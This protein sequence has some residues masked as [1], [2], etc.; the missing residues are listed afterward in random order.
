[1]LFNK[2]DSSFNHFYL[3]RSMIDLEKGIIV[4]CCC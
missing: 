2:E 3:E 4:S 1:L